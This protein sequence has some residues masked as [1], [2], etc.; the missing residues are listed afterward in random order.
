MTHRSLPFKVTPIGRFGAVIE[1]LDFNELMD[2]HTVWH[3]RRALATFQLLIF[4]EQ[5]ISPR[6][7]LR[8]TKYFG[9]LESGI[10][11]R[12]STHQVEEYPELLYIRNTPGS[13]TLDYGSAWHSDGLAYARVPHGATVLRC[14]DCPPDAGDTLFANQYEAYDAIPESIRESMDGLYWYLPPIDYSE[15]PDGKSLVQPLIR[16]H[17]ETGRNFIYHAPQASQLR[18][19]TQAESARI[20]DIINRCQVR[21][22]LIYRHS[23]QPQ[24]VIVWENCTLLHNRADTVDFATHGLRAMHRSATSG[25]FAAIEC[26]AP[27]Q[28]K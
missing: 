27:P 2:I 24:D 16:T 7:Q 8:L 13:P 23:W 1:G 25:Q 9:N 26:G 10:A 20:L 17:P 5:A 6:Q 14:I 3:L 15:V 21:G 12:P 28:P 4:R 22:D 11:R 19:K 18:G